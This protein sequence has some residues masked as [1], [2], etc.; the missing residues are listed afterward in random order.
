MKTRIRGGA[1][2]EERRPRSARHALQSAHTSLESALVRIL[3]MLG[4]ERSIG[5][6]WPVDLIR[7]VAASLPGRH[8]AILSARLA[9]A[10]DETRRFRHRATHTYGDFR[11]PDAAPTIEAAAALAKELEAKIRTFKGIIDPPARTER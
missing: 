7:R 2:E 5:D 6:N 8:P 11:A 10:A 4:E 3:D 9:D 1:S